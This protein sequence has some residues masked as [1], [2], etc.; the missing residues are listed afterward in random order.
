[1]LPGALAAMQPGVGNQACAPCHV[2]IYRR[3]AATGMARS[4][5]VVS[6]AAPK[7]SFA[8][9]AFEDPASAAAYQITPGQDSYRLSFART[10]TDIHGERSLRWFVGS[11]SVGRSYLFSTGGFL[12]QAPVSY[13]AL[14]ERW[15]VSPGFQR[16]STIALT[17]PVEPACL[18][19]HASRL[20]TLPGTENGFAAVPFLENGVACERCHGDAREHIA[21]HGAKSPIL[22]NPAKL[23]P[24][25]RDSICAQ[26]HLSGVARIARKRANAEPWK[27]GLLLSDFS[28]F[29]V[30]AGSELPEMRVTSHFER[31]Q[32]SA[33]KRASGDKL[34]CGSCHDPHEEPAPE[35]RAAYYRAKCA[36]C[37][38]V[39]HGEDCIGCH[40]PKGQVSDSQHAVYTDHS[41]PRRPRPA[42]QPASTDTLVPF[43]TTSANDRDL[44]LAYAVAAAAKPALR[45]RSLPLLEA[46]AKRDPDD[47]AVLVQLAQDYDQAGSTER[48]MPL[49]QRVLTLNPA[50]VAAAT[51]LGAILAQRGNAAEAIRLWQQALKANPALTN[52]RMNLAVAQY[53]A[54]DIAGAR[55][56]LEQALQYDPDTAAARK[57]LFE[58]KST[59]K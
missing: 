33:C 47:A 34:W 30:W 43:W 16:Y 18:Q 1:M 56:T 13:Y 41:I 15:D 19:C 52:V 38:T 53:R 10:G 27:P 50:S 31:L 40:M 28:A 36:A 49:Y 23:S 46:A 42:A 11:G 55:T 3:Y 44:G 22:V 17:R 8:R 32:Q 20:Q 39:S 58:L 6:S 9:A 2:D 24:A 25:R 59:V 37:H 5:G 21:S 4:S 48:A 14:G 26:C 35:N 7:E 12:F 51:N 57:L 45:A 54:G 29:F